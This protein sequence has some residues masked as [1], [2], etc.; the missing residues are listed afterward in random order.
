MPRPL[1]PSRRY[2]AAAAASE[3]LRCAS[4]YCWYGVSGCAMVRVG[5]RVR[6][7][8]RVKVRVRVGLRLRLRGRVRVS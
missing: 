8:V 7:R 6:V 2:R 1:P 5:L 3:Y 4:R